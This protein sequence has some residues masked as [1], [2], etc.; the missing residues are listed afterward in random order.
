VLRGGDVAAEVAA[1]KDQPGGDLLL[2]LTSA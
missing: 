1:I 2:N